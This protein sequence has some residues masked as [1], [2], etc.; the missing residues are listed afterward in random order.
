[1]DEQ[2]FF[3]EKPTKA[4]GM[5][6]VLTILTFIGSGVGILLTIATPFISKFFMGFMEKGMEGATLS[7]SQLAD[8]EKAK[9]AFALMEKNMTLLIATGIVACVL[10]IAGAIMMRKLKKEGYFV[11]VAGRVLPLIVG[12]FLLG[13]V[14]FEGGSAIGGIVFAFLMI[15]LYTTQR[16]QLIN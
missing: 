11:Y 15:I 1:M 5:L 16:K 3:E 14:A 9:A 13:K 2:N 7:D 10:C 6:N 8:I 4:T 12:A